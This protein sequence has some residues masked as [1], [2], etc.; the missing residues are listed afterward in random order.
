MVVSVLDWV[1]AELVRLSHNVPA[2]EAQRIVEE[3]VTRQVP[4]I[5]DFN[6]FLKVLRPDLQASDQIPADYTADQL[7]RLGPL[8][9]AQ[10]ELGLAP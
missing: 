3:L 8:Q 4:A 7:L 10:R 5:Q 1:M 2:D 6:G 9:A